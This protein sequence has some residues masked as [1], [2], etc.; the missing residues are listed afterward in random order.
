MYISQAM[1]PAMFVTHF[2]QLVLGV[3]MAIRAAMPRPFASRARWS[4]PLCILLIGMML[5]ATFLVTMFARPPNFCFASL[6]W[7]VHRWKSGILICLCLIIGFLFISVVIITIR[8]RSNARASDEMERLAA[9]RMVFY[10]AISIA[11]L[12]CILPFFIQSMLMDLVTE[13][14][15]LSKYGMVASVV[16]NLL[17]II[18]FGCFI[19]L[20]SKKMDSAELDDSFNPEKGMYNEQENDAR[21]DSINSDER[22][23]NQIQQPLTPPH[24]KTDILSPSPRAPKIQDSITPSVYSRGNVA[25]PST[26]MRQEVPSLPAQQPTLPQTPYIHVRESSNDSTLRNPGQQ[27]PSTPG[28]VL[29]AATYQPFLSPGLVPALSDLALPPRIGSP[30]SHHRA[31]SLES[32]AT[33][34][35]GLRLSNVNDI[36]SLEEKCKK[37]RDLVYDL[38]CPNV[39]SFRESKR[40]LPGAVASG[41]LGAGAVDDRISAMSVIIARP[42]DDVVND[43]GE[44]RLSPTVYNPNNK[45]AARQTDMS[46]TS[47]YD[48]DEVNVVP[49][50][51]FSRKG[52]DWI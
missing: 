9:Y 6:F 46:V 11:S 3:E 13:V 7:L 2:I 14:Y 32:T 23:L 29:P 30:A 26:T 8:L 42:Q 10:L 22:W 16:A 5:L 27:Q 39:G 40:P 45:A 17:G 52:N 20:R 34:Q 51:L 19:F 44:I 15:E 43:G 1:L 36:P 18:V 50:P 24:Y 35:I 38:N 47:R 25:Q 49:D 12:G 21:T 33:V 31:A 28:W 41:A 4:T 37:E 48:D